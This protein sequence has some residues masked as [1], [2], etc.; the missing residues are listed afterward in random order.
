MELPYTKAVASQ[1]VPPFRGIIALVRP[2]QWVKNGFVAAPL[3]LTPTA[4]SLQTVLTIGLAILAFSAVAS[5]VY[6]LNDYADRNADKQHHIKR[7]RP[8]ASGIVPIP[9]AFATMGFLMLAGFSLAI[10]LYPPFALILATYAALNVGYSLGLKNI[11]VVDVFII[12][13]GFVLRVQAGILLI[14]VSATVWITIMTWLLALFIALAK[15]RDD[16][17]RSMT[18]A[19]RT[20]LSGYN[21]PFLDST[22]TMLLGALLVAYLIYTTDQTVMDRMGTDNLVYSAP[23]VVAGIMRYLQLLFVE[24]RSGNP[25]EIVLTDRFLILTIVGWALCMALLIYV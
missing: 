11:A 5:A 14:G 16:V 1:L 22:V 10:W 13:I 7:Y 15:R 23:F 4:V 8:L 17:I 2:R 9:A 3:F 24:E 20:S 21:R 19:H 12:A 25:T 18:T 6:V